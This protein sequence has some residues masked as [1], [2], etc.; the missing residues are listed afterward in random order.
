MQ[1][2]LDLDVDAVADAS[3]DRTAVELLGGGCAVGE[4]IDEGRV[5]HKFEGCLRHADS[6]GGAFEHNLSVGAVA[7]TYLHALWQLDGSLDLEE[8]G[9]VLLHSLGG[10]VFEG[11]VEFQ[12]LDGTHSDFHRHA[13]ND[14]AHFRLVNLAAKDEVLHV[15]DSGDGGTVVEGVAKD[16]RITY[17][18]RHIEHDAVDS[19]ADEGRTHLGIVERDTVPDDV[20]GILG[21]VHLH[22]GILQRHLRLLVVFGTHHLLRVEVLHAVEVR[23]SLLERNLS[24]LHTILS[25][26]EVRHVWDDLHFGNHLVLL[27]HIASLLVEFCDD[28]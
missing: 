28:A 15:G 11:G 3:G 23:L 22:L 18:D 8:V 16:D 4:H 13:C 21:V 10:N 24:Q 12:V 17:L 1:S 27:H 25:A 20:E 2:L 9:T 6:L 7:G 14:S 26:A 5:A 19:R